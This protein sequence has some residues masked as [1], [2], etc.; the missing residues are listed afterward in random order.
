[1]P[2]IKIIILSIVLIIT[3]T[4]SLLSVDTPFNFLRYVQSARAAGLSGA[5][6]T[7]TDDP[8]AVFFNP[9]TISTVEN[10]QASATFLKHVLDINSGNVNYVHALEG[11][12][13]LA[14]NIG[15]TSYGSFDYADNLGNRNRGT[16][17]ANDLSIGVSYSDELDTN[18]FYGV[19]LKYIFV[20]IEQVSTSAMAVDAGLLYR[21]RD[22][23]TNIGLSVLHAGMQLTTISNQNES[24]PLDLRIGVNH[25][26]RG[27]PLLFNFN[28]HHLADDTDSFFDKFKS[29][30]LGGEFYFGEVVQVRLGYDNQIRTFTAPEADKGLTGISAGLG[31]TFEDFNFDYGFS[32]YGSNANLHRFSVS[33]N[34][35]KL[36]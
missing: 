36:F 16:F 24:L 12:G 31:L 22:G 27:L 9:A 19:T 2:G 23:R 11:T 18:F 5:F 1:M 20:G 10:H 28:F 32:R 8:T 34:V 15:F 4:A 30:S 25:R 3:N 7:M 33:L 17:G 21:L 29:F 13:T 26:L 35:N 6:T 14:A